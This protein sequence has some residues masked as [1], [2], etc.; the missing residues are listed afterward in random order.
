M[1]Y[2]TR[3]TRITVAP[4]NERIFSEMATHVEIADEA[5]GE[6]I[7]IRQSIGRP[8]EGEVR[9]EPEEWPSIRDAVDM[10]IKNIRNESK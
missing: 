7:V 6:F 2:E 10:M 3:V 4:K 5:A 9:I 1:N 8:E